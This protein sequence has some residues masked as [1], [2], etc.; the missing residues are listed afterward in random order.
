MTTFIIVILAVLSV[1]GS[2][3]WVR[4]S[5]RDVKLAKWRQQARVSGLQV[6][7]E[8]LQAEPKESGIREDVTG[9]SYTLFLPKALKGD[10]LTWAVVKADG[11][12]KDGLPQEWSW[13][14]K[15][16]PLDLSKLCALIESSPIPIY[17]IE[18]T[19]NS[20]RIIWGEEGIEFDAP[21]LN[22][23]LQKAQAIS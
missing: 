3:V 23:F 9:A 8:G 21:Q 11:W 17:A 12:L 20:S 6:K 5:H 4:P 1:V 14:L 7:L 2:V 15:E 10:E 16:A 18:R 19:P 22:E 13:Y